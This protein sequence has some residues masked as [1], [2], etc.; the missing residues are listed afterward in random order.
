MD[1]PTPAS[2]IGPHDCDHDT[3]PCFWCRLPR[4]E[5][6]ETITDNMSIQGDA[7]DR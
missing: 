5:P 1:E 7:D 4:K 3:C 6:M 2:H